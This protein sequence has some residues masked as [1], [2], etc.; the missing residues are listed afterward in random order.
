MIAGHWQT[1]GLRTGLGQRGLVAG[2]FVMYDQPA[3]RADALDLRLEFVP[4]A[5]QERYLELAFDMARGAHRAL[6]GRPIFWD[7]PTDSLI[8]M[9]NS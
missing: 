3:E 4:L 9:G 8:G 7:Q 5:V 2:Q 1:G 6:G